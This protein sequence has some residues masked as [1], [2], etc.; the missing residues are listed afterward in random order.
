MHMANEQLRKQELSNA[1]NSMQSIGMGEASQQAGKAAFQMGNWQQQEA[2]R[3]ADEAAQ[4]AGVMRSLQTGGGLI[5]GAFGLLP[6]TEGGGLGGLFKG[7]LAGLGGDYGMFAPK[8]GAGVNINMA[9]LNSDLIN[10]DSAIKD[11][12]R[13]QLKD[14]GFSDEE[15]AVIIS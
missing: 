1:I 8:T 13:Q 10:S 7:G 3:R 14:A 15:I 9:G 5:G 11:Q 6:G 12:Q 4:Q 2:Q